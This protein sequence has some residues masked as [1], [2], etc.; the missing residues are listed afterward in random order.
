[1]IAAIVVPLWAL[2][3][4]Y[5]VGLLVFGTLFAYLAG[6]HYSDDEHEGGAKGYCDS[7]WCS[8]EFPVP[9]IIMGWPMALVLFSLMLLVLYPIYGAIM[10]VN[11]LVLL[12]LGKWFALVSRAPYASKQVLNQHPTAVPI[13]KTRV[14]K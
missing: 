14:D 7:V 4:A 9:L 5:F 13:E 1:M 11:K 8:Q 3:I 6:R 12:P 10:L 2:P